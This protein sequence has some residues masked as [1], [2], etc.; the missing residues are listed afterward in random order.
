MYFASIHEN[1]G[2]KPVEIFLSKEMG[3][4]EL[5]RG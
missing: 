3:E 4:R 1:R 2:M 5:W